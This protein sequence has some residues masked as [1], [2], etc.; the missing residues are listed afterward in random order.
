MVLVPMMVPIPLGKSPQ[1]GSQ[2]VRALFRS[3]S[4]SVSIGWSHTA[5]LFFVKHGPR[6][7]AL[8]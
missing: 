4:Y 2:A 8:F 1:R 6:V 5:S 3:R 7:M